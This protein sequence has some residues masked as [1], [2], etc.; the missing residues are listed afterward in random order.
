MSLKL[1]KFNA[2]VVNE[3]ENVFLAGIKL[4]IVRRIVCH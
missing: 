3:I 2:S 1:Y 4:K